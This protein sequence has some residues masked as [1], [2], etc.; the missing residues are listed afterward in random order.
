M[1]RGRIKF[2]LFVI[3]LVQYAIIGMATGL[4]VYRNPSL[5]N[6]WDGYL[7]YLAPV[8]TVLILYIL[9][10]S[11]IYSFVPKPAVKDEEKKELEEVQEEASDLDKFPFGD[12]D[13][14]VPPKEEVYDDIL[15]S[16]ALQLLALFQREG[17]LLDFLQEDIQQYD[18]AQIGAAVREVHEKCSAALNETVHLEPVLNYPEGSEVEIDDFYDPKE[19]KLTGK[20]K[21]KPP[22]KG[23]LQHSGW[24]FTQVQLPP[25]KAMLTRKIISPAEVQVL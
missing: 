17:R 6:S 14:M 24:K 25:K 12:K 2:R 15:K 5:L 4:V 8:V 10:L 23:I 21:G 18:D 1:D 22:F 19:I 9:G 7:L 3:C 13:F 11:W 20:V 16:G